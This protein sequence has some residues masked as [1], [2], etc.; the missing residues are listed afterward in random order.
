MKKSNRRIENTAMYKAILSLKTE[1]ECRK[2]M[3]DLCIYNSV[4]RSNYL[5]N[6]VLK[7]FP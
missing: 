5:L 7:F 2:F 1:E 3:E 4:A 6:D